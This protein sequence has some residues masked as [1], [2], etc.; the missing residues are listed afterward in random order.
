MGIIAVLLS[1]TKKS[2]LPSFPI[3]WFDVWRNPS[4]LVHVRRSPLPV[5]TAHSPTLHIIFSFAS[6]MKAIFA[7]AYVERGKCLNLHLWKEFK[8]FSFIALLF[9]TTLLSIWYYL[10]FFNIL[11]FLISFV[12]IFSRAG[13]LSLDECMMLNGSFFSLHRDITFLAM[14]VFC[15]SVT[16]GNR[17]VLE[18]SHVAL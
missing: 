1:S 4:L 14:L 18:I 9:I 17:I 10:Q 15:W 3:G 7:I 8:N 2:R 6:T 11:E 13:I 16:K 12:T 5:G